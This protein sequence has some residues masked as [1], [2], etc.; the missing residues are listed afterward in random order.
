[1]AE[2]EVS[3]QKRR[4]L[5]EI[6][7]AAAIGGLLATLL[8]CQIWLYQGRLQ[9]AA[10]WLG[11]DLRA[12]EQ[13]VAVSGGAAYG[14]VTYE[15]IGHSRLE[16]LVLKINGQNAGSFSGPQVTLRVS[17]GDELEL[18]ASAYHAPVRVRL[19]RASAGIDTSRLLY[20]VMLCGGRVGLGR[21]AI[22]RIEIE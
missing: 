9:P 18:D 7:L 19:R 1:M 17:P 10:S 22:E 16:R 21:V 8:L 20:D 3:W 12:A 5:F 14:T 13:S 6:F 15:L 2:R 4:R 11:S